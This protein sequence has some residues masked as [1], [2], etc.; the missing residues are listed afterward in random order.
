MS[1]VTVYGSRLL[2]MRVIG[3]ERIEIERLRRRLGRLVAAL[4]E[5]M[6]DVPADAPGAWSPPVD[7]C[8]SC[9]A[10]V[11][12]VDLPGV[13]AEEIEL[14]LTSTA[15]RVSGRKKRRAARGAVSHICSERGYGRFERTVPLRW[16]IKTRGATAVLENGLLTV[17]L[18][19]L[20]DRRG[21]EYKIPIKENDER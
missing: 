11:V 18:P 8:E 6:D 7:L 4:Q 9:D 17:R 2:V 15:L 3:L 19:K 1:P 16:S 21:E 14:S 12:R 13:A 10:V 5:V 20:A